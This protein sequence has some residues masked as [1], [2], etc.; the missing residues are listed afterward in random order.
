MKTAVIAFSV[1][2]LLA[3]GLIFTLQ[4]AN[5]LPGSFMTGSQFWLVAGLIMMAAGGGLLWFAGRIGRP[6]PPA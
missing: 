3:P 6:V 5:I 4:G 2:F 1:I